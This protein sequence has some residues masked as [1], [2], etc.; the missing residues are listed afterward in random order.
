MTLKH[1]R[2][3][4]EHRTLAAMV[5]IYCS[6]HHGREGNLCA[7]CAALLD[8]AAVRLERCVFQN[9]KP[10]CAKC[11]VHCYRA[12]WRDQVKEIMRYAGPRMVW[13]HP[14]LAVRHLLDGK[15]PVPALKR[16]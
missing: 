12:P 11:P 10:T 2:L 14:V 3:V 6:D 13:R 9:E 1:P 15:R 16:A 4:R 7:E 8:Y 5:E